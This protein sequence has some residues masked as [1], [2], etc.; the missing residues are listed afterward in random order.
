MHTKERFDIKC[1]IQARSDLKTPTFAF[2]WLPPHVYRLYNKERRNVCAAL[3][4]GWLLMKEEK[5]DRMGEC[6]ARVKK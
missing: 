1:H 5:E 3:N 2:L 6:V 4:I